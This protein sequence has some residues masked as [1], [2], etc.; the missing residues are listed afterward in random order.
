MLLVVTYSSLQALSQIR[1]SYY[2]GR[3][4]LLCLKGLECCRQNKELEK[5]NE[6]IQNEKLH[7]EEEKK[8]LA[9]NLAAVV[10]KKLEPEPKFNLNTPI[11][12]TL[13]VLR[14]LIKVSP[15]VCLLLCRQDVQ[16]HLH[17]RLHSNPRL[18]IGC[19]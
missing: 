3:L 15:A 13:S 8:T 7:L 4:V 17:L 16:L 5:L 9:Q 18:L 14:S 10:Q 11:D 6:V 1:A 12:E 2:K 19:Y